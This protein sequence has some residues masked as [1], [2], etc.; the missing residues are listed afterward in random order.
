VS[1]RR[2]SWDDP[3]LAIRG[4]LDLV[5]TENG[6]APR[7]L[8]AWTVRR[9]PD[10]AL[11]S[12]AR[13]T[14]GVRL[15]CSTS[16][17]SLT[18]EILE[19]G[20]Q[21]GAEPRRPVVFDLFVDGA[22]LARLEALGGHTLKIDAEGPVASVRLE[23]GL[24]STLRFEGL[25]PGPK[26]LE[27]WAPQSA[28]VELRG[29]FLDAD[30][31][32]APAPAQGR[33]WAH[34]GSSI[35]HGMEADGPSETWPAVAARAAGVELLNLGFAGQ[36]HLDG[37]VA[38]T[39]AEVGADLISLKLGI[40]VVNGDSMRE[41]V[42]VDRAHDLLDRLRAAGPE[43][44]IVLI[45]P[46]LCPAHESD[47]GPTQRGPSGV[48][49]PPRPA[50]LAAG[51]LSL[52]RIREILQGIAEARRAQ[53]DRRLHYLDGLALFGEG[54]VGDL[55]DG[56][57]PNAAGLIRMGERFA[58]WAFAPGGPFNEAG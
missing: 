53:G 16:S 24:P 32:L 50:E 18:L 7:R 58:A 31:E 39:L 6:R 19:T 9:M 26:R 33:V 46:I 8:P 4:A 17:R 35:S 21:L 51:A 43:T 45:S 41:R 27:L 55:P 13:M 15:A 23:P 40:N 47:P 38:R 52:R 20:F 49:A 30:A 1:R 2:V 22:R 34:Y 5:V 11:E 54:D 28:W 12:V 57:H 14:S 29:L 42:F 10:P 56:L 36:C 3:A 37:L 48:I 25:P 44:P